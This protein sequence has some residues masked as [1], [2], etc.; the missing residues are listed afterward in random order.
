MEL[1]RPASVAAGASGDSPSI[2]DGK[3]EQPVVR[4]SVDS[5]TL[6][7]GPLS[8]GPVS[9]EPLSLIPSWARKRCSSSP[10]L[11]VILSVM[12]SRRRGRAPPWRSSSRQ[13]STRRVS[14]LGHMP[15]ATALSRSSISSWMSASSAPW[16]AAL[17]GGH[18]GGAHRASRCGWLAPRSPRALPEPR[19]GRAGR[20]RQEVE[21]AA[22]AEGTPR[23]LTVPTSAAD[24]SFVSQCVRHGWRALP[25]PPRGRARC[26]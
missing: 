8:A 12:P 16:A 2:V 17:C 1:G 23:A 10:T 15:S 24:R 11:K 6:S 20:W 18:V 13:I 7:P 4:C 21:A 19:P 9:P 25:P 26:R 3:R 5:R 22:V 14:A